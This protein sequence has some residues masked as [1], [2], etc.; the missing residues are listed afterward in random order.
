MEEKYRCLSRLPRLRSS[1]IQS[2]CRSRNRE[3]VRKGLRTGVYPRKERKER[4]IVFNHAYMIY[5]LVD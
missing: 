3:T 4:V 1:A 5:R 2:N